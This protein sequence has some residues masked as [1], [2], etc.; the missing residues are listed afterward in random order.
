MKKIFKVVIFLLALVLAIELSKAV[1]YLV[2]K[3]KE[4]FNF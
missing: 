4:S 2:E 1:F 3:E